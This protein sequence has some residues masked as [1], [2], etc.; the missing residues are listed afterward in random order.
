MSSRNHYEVFENESELHRMHGV[1][2]PMYNE[3]YQFKD[4][5]HVARIINPAICDGAFDRRPCERKLKYIGEEHSH[6]VNG[7][8]Y[9][10]IDFNG[11]T[12]SIKDYTE[13]SGKVIGFAF[14][15][16]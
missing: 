16:N 15:L 13:K 12:Y 2:H 14:F 3:L 8:E 5:M 4:F 11:A 6:F 7:E 1:I 10:A 9:D